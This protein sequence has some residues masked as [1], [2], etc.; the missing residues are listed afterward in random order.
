M[1]LWIDDLRPM[2]DTFD[3]H[4]KTASEAIEILKRGKVTHASFDHD[5]G[6]EENGTGYDVASWVDN[7]ASE[8]TIPPFTWTIHSANPVGA[9]NIRAALTHA[10]KLWLKLN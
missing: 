6:E 8:K 5:L 10:S 9:A 4:A 3:V 2:P 7:A 1:K